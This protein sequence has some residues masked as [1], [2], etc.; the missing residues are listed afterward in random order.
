MFYI[1]E[2][3][4]YIATIWTSNIHG[5]SATLFLSPTAPLFILLGYS[6]PALKEI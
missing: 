3:L 6:T 1:S 4:I 5:L 2:T